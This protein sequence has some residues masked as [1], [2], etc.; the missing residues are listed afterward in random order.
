M[1]KL[2]VTTVAL[3]SVAYAAV[4]AGQISIR[5]RSGELDANGRGLAEFSRHDTDSRYSVFQGET[6]AIV[7]YRPN[8]AVGGTM[9]TLIDTSTPLPPPLVGTFNTFANTTLNDWDDV[10]FTAKL[11]APQGEGVFVLEGTGNLIEL[12][13]GMSVVGVRIAPDINGRGDVVWAAESD[14]ELRFWDRTLRTNTIF[15]TRGG[16]NVPSSGG[17]WRRF[18]RRPVVSNEDQ[19]V[20]FIG[21]V[22]GAPDGI[23]LYDAK[24]R[25][26]VSVARTGDVSPY[27]GQT[28][29]SFGLEDSIAIDPNGRVAFVSDLSGGGDGVF[30]FDP[31]TGTTTL[32]GRSGVGV[33]NGIALIEAIPKDHV[34]INAFGEITFVGEFTTPQGPP[35]R[36]LLVKADTSTGIMKAESPIFYRGNFTCP[37]FSTSGVVWDQGGTVRQSVDNT[38]FNII[39]A[40]WTVTP[41]GSGTVHHTPCIAPS[42]GRIVFAATHK[43]LYLQEAGAP[44]EPLIGPGDPSPRGALFTV[45]SVESN[46]YGEDGVAFQVTDAGPAGSPRPHAIGWAKVTNPS[47]IDRI[48]SSSDPA[49]ASV[50]GGTFALDRTTA[51]A[52]NDERVYFVSEIDGST[53]GVTQ[54]IFRGGPSAT[55]IPRSVI[56]TGA[57][58]PGGTTFAS[59]DC[60][61]LEVAQRHVL[62]RGTLSSGAHGLF[63]V[64]DSGPGTLTTIAMAG[65]RAAGTNSEFASFGALA[66]NRAREVTFAAETAAGE[67]GVWFH[68][69]GTLQ[70]AA[71]HGEPAAVTAGGTM[72]FYN[73][74]QM[75]LASGD[76]SGALYVAH[77]DGA[78]VAFEALQHTEFST[79][80][81]IV[82]APLLSGV[83]QA[84]VAGTVRQLD[85]SEPI[86][87]DQAL[88][89][90]IFLFDDTDYRQAIVGFTY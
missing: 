26:I 29:G 4:A 61:A 86:S 19:F 24:A 89:Y 52:V 16:T 57:S 65:T 15:A 9:G 85:V 67:L 45:R 43:K 42:S 36:R 47:A 2:M 60:D 58:G 76:N 71:L 7:M 55:A 88:A 17:A 79:A 28:Y 21:D 32:A 54:G 73:W 75:S 8:I 78:P 3:A 62:F 31:I 12:S 41:L 14:Y 37:R 27:N 23:F 40:G 13:A 64:R 49:P 63:L 90:G 83:T 70:L 6:S 51:V 35:L 10:V 74:A 68:S 66:I 39:S 59:F 87:V 25:S 11:N 1:R 84:P 46:A 20:A 72:E 34:G 77:L 44:I 80:P 56:A 53:T 30:L 33:A 48:V 22:D 38:T 5:T 82:T 18:G 81:P 69:N 50:G